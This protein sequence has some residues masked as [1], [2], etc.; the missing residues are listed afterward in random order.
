MSWKTRDRQMFSTNEQAMLQVTKQT[1]VHYLLS[2]WVLTKK[3]KLKC[4]VRRMVK[5]SLAN[6]YI[7]VG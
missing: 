5:L 1:L 4:M 7:G 3:K 6:N 2:L